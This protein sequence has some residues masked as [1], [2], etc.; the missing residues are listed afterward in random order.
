[1]A[2]N[3]LR[4]LAHVPGLPEDTIKA[5]A[6]TEPRVPGFPKWLDIEHPRH[7]FLSEE[8][9][10]AATEFGVADAQRVHRTFKNQSDALAARD[11][12]KVTFGVETVE[13]PTAKQAEGATAGAEADSK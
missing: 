10:A 5:L 2:S 13:V 8:I 9:A 6:G 7:S 1:M 3:G 11:G 12:A 4:V